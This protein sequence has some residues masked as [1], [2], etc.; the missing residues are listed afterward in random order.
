MLQGFRSGVDSDED[1]DG[2]DRRT[3]FP[4]GPIAS[5]LKRHPDALPK[6]LSGR[7]KGSP[8]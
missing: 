8:I 7:E 3:P 4:L 1:R 6:F 2:R 5:S